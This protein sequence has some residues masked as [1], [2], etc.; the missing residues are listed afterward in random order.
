MPDVPVQPVHELKLFPLAVAGASGPSEGHNNKA[1]VKV[2]GM[3]VPERTVVE[4]VRARLE[5][6]DI[7][8]S[9]PPGADRPVSPG[10][11]FT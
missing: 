10:S 5:G 3:M 9:R 11:C 6:H 4:W 8:D 1:P 7:R 2:G